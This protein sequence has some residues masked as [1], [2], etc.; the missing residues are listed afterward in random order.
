VDIKLIEITG[1]EPLA[2][3][4]TIEL[5]KELL[6][7]GFKVLIE[8]NGSLSIEKIPKDVIKILDCKSPSSG[9][10]DNM[11]FANFALLS[12][13]DEVKFVIS[14][15][16]DYDYACGI[17]KKYDLSTKINNILFSPMSSSPGITENL[18]EWIVNDKLPVRMQLQMHKI[19]W[20][21][22]ERGR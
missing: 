22:D 3:E 11:D 7:A 14:D 8:T 17:I 20:N 2:Q 5:C 18:A 21:E 9:E 13:K 10:C 15:K 1:G 6:H 19:I 12:Q 4:N 16:R